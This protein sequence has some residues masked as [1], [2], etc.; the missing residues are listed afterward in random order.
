MEFAK[1]KPE[2]TGPNVSTETY[3][4]LVDDFLNQYPPLDEYLNVELISKPDGK[5]FMVNSLKYQ[6]DSLSGYITVELVDPAE[7]IYNLPQRLITAIF[8]RE[9]GPYEM[10]IK[11]FKVFE[12]GENGTFKNEQVIPLTEKTFKDGIF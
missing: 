1:G 12:Y 6:P 11:D 8:K 2:Y 4:Q 7:V 3:L 5:T 9:P 10:L